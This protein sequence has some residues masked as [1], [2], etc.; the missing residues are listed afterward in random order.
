MKEIEKKLNKIIKLLEPTYT[1]VG[2]ANKVISD[3][4]DNVISLK[5]TLESIEKR[6]ISIE[7][8]IK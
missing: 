4:E 2:N 6:V 5:R 7:N 3:I 1:N 8:K